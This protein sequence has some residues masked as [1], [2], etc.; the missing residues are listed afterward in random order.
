MKFSALGS[1][2]AHPA[3]RQIRT[4]APEHLPRLKPPLTSLFFCC[5]V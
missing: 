4:S 5:F 3:A 1:G 2:A